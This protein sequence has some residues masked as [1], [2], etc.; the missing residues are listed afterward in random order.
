VRV[1]DNKSIV[2]DQIA[3][4]LT[5]IYKRPKHIINVKNEI[6]FTVGKDAEM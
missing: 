2:E 6:D 1:Y 3:K 4:Y 5:E